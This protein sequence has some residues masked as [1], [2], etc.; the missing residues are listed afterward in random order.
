M[1][2]KKTLPVSNNKITKLQLAILIAWLGFTLLAF[3]YFITDKLVSFDSNEKLKNVDYQ[4]LSTFLAPY[5]LPIEGNKKQTVLH[6]STPTC[7]CQKYSDEHIQEINELAAK[8]DFTI[9]NINI[10]KHDIIPSTPSIALI[11][12]SGEIIYFG[13]YGQGLACSQ[14][15]GYAQTILNNFIKGYNENIVIK[16]AKGCYCSV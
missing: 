4:K 10:E 14:T 12:K 1:K 11:D 5:S 7:N 16:E 3:G 8:H 6:F 13:P 9:K 15:T 2:W